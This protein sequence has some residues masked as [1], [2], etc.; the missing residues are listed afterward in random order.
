M[1]ILAVFEGTVQSGDHG[2]VALVLQQGLHGGGELKRINTRF[3][4]NSLVVFDLVGIEPT[5]ET[6][7]NGVFLTRKKVAAENPVRDIHHD[8]LLVREQSLVGGPAERWQER[9]SQGCSAG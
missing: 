5:Y 2:Y 8:Q 1:N 4:Q 7:Q 9:Q 6:R 3:V